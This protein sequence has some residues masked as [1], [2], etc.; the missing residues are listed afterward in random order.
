MATTRTTDPSVDEK[1]R[2]RGP[3]KERSGTLAMSIKQFCDR[4]SISEAFY[5]ELRKEGK[6]PD[7]MDVDGRVLISNEAAARW[8][9]ERERTAA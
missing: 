8:R 9:A 4:H 1:E 5:Y 6:G 2:K 7:T 3:A